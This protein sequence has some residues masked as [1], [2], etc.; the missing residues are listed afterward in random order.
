MHSLRSIMFRAGNWRVTMLLLCWDEMELKCIKYQWIYKNLDFACIEYFRA[1]EN[2]INTSQVP[3][4]LFKGQCMVR[5]VFGPQ[6]TWPDLNI[7]GK[8][9]TLSRCRYWQSV[10]IKIISIYFGRRGQKLSKS[11]NYEK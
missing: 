6:K 2:G 10:L 1:D 5:V 8:K 7:N 4:G 11:Y 3:V 9:L